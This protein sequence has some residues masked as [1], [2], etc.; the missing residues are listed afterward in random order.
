MKLIRPRYSLLAL[1]LFTAAVAVGV[2]LWRGPHRVVNRTNPKMEEEYTYYFDWNGSKIMDGVR[3]MRY[4]PEG[5]HNRSSV[6]FYRQG[7]CLVAPTSVKADT[8]EQ[9]LTL[10][11]LAQNYPVFSPEELAQFHRQVQSER[12]QLIRNS[13]D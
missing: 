9:R 10:Q 4:S 12:E 1:L 7:K 11:A 2:K 8:E 13:G 6:H 3:V 5:K